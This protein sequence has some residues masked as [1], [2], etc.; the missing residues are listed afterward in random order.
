MADSVLENL[1]M[2]LADSLPG[3]NL[4]GHHLSMSASDDDS[5]HDNGFRTLWLFEYLLSP[6]LHSPQDSITYMDF[7]YM[8]RIV[9][10]TLATI[11]TFD[12]SFEPAYKL[13][14]TG[15]VYP[16]LRSFAITVRCFRKCFKLIC[17]ERTKRFAFVCTNHNPLIHF[18][19]IKGC[20]QVTHGNVSQAVHIVKTAPTTRG[21]MAALRE[22]LGKAEKR[23]SL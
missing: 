9:K 13:H 23:N 18:F 15:P 6:Y 12:Q 22:F 20:S 1:W 3:I 21:M 2:G 19:S 10:T 7:D 11:H 4:N 14:M 8:T 16:V 17:D 5:F